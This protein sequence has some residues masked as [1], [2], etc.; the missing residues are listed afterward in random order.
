MF[1]EDRSLK[2]EDFVWTFKY[3]PKTKD[4]VIVL[5]RMQS[6]LEKMISTKSVP[7]LLL[8]GPPGTGKTSFINVLINEVGFS[9]LRINGSRD[10]SIE[11]VRNDIKKFTRRS[12]DKPKLVFI[13]E[14]ERMSPN[15]LD[16]LKTEMEDCQKTGFVFTS[17]HVEKIIDPIKSR[18][19]GGISFYF[20]NDEKKEL[21]KKYYQ[22]CINILEQENVEFEKKAVAKV[23][24]T[25]FPDMR[26]IIHNLQMIYNQHESIT[27]EAVTS[28]IDTD[29]KEFFNLIKDGDFDKIRSYCINLNSS[30]ELFYGNVIRKVEK[31]V[32]SDSIPEM[33]DLCYEHNKATIGNADPMIPMIHFCFSIIDLNLK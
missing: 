24:T 14:A 11:V 16:S 30:Y 8:Y 19:G 22:R 15:A 5:N 6:L 17:N 9:V 31:Y 3:A 18:C 23:V 12:T 4:D 10:T 2:K 7:D 13:D 27:L 1:E 26:N 28:S 33:I 25:F 29:L 20:N 32:E 21:Q